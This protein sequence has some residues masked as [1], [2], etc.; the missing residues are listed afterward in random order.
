MCVFVRACIRAAVRVCVTC[1]VCVCV[2]VCIIFVCFRCFSFFL[3]F[4]ALV[5]VYAGIVVG[6]FILFLIFNLLS[7]VIVI[8]DTHQCFFLYNTA[9]MLSRIGCMEKQRLA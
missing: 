8:T 9:F 2:C 7:K 4:F 5:V 3:F 1:C 6:I